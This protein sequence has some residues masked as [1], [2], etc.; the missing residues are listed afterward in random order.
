MKF[1]V[2]SFLKRSEKPEKTCV[3]CIHYKKVIYHDRNASYCMS[4]THT[5]Y[6]SGETYVER[7]CCIEMRKPSGWCG[8]GGRRF[9]QLP[10]VINS[11]ASSN[12]M[13]GG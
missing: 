6:V 3:N 10:V 5:D 9:K 12:R 8:P 13:K 2:F 1:N 11:S 7:K 4:E